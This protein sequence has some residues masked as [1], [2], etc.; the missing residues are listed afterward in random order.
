MV[1]RPYAFSSGET[2]VALLGEEAGDEFAEG[3]ADGGGEGADEPCDWKVNKLPFNIDEVRQY[4][5]S[6]RMS[7][8]V[9]T[10]DVDADTLAQANEV[11][12]KEGITLTDALHRMMLYIVSEGRMPRFQCYEP[13]EETLAAIAEAESGDL[14]TVGTVADL[15]AELNED[16]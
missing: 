6:Q 15:M 8:I 9:F 5:G 4:A 14:I 16:D 2:A 1:V 13:S 3:V 12:S 7:T 11:L 10:A